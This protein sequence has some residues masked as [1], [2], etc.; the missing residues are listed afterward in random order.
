MKR[1][2][3]TAVGIAALCAGGVLA[4]PTAVAAPG[5]SAVA[6]EA[7]VNAAKLHIY[8]HDDYKGG[9]H[10]FAKSDRD[11]TN[12]LWTGAANSVNNGASSMRNKTSRAAVLY[13]G[14]GFTGRTYYAKK[15][16]SDSDLS[17]N[18]FDNRASSLRFL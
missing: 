9:Y 8:R 13:D 11:F 12:N 17:N 4:A 16:S 6:S 10:G 15:H 5:D 14:R 1:A 2:I 18:G 3:A 7:S